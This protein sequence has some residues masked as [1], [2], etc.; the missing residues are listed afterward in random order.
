MGST[1]IEFLADRR[2]KEAKGSG[3]PNPRGALRH[4]DAAH[5]KLEQLQVWRRQLKSDYETCIDE[6]DTAL[7]A[8]DNALQEL[9]EKSRILD[10]KLALVETQKDLIVQLLDELAEIE[11]GAEPAPRIEFAS[12]EAPALTTRVLARLSKND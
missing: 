8:L 5:V 11:N 1:N 10:E 7:L 2:P 9:D 3:A 12:S 6:R 4:L